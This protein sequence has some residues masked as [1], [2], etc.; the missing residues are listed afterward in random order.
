MTKYYAHHEFDIESDDYQVVYSLREIL[1]VRTKYSEE[2]YAGY[3]SAQDALL[4]HVAANLAYE[5]DKYGV[6]TRKNLQ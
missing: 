5:S 6:C 4:D 1:Y 2:H 3:S